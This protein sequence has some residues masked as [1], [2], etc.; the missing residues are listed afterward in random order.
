MK[1]FY[2]Q[3]ILLF[4]LCS[5]AFTINSSTN[6]NLQGWANSEIEFL[7]NDSSCPSS[8]DVQ[9]IMAEAVEIW[10][11]VSTSSLK[12]KIGGTTTST[13]YADKPTVYCETN[14]AGLSGSPDPN[15]VPGAAAVIGSTGSITHGLFF[16]NASAGLAN[17]AN[18]DRTTLKIIFA[19]EIGHILGLG[20]S[21]SLNALM[22]YDA[23]EKKNFRLSQD[24]ID[25]VS[26]LYPSNELSDSKIAGCGLVKNLPPPSGGE[27]T[28]IL[29]LLLLPFSLYNGLKIKNVPNFL[30]H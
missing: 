25:G 2:F 9:G 15:Y 10:N 18:F 21:E 28:L 11:N 16:L 23:S 14:F 1:Y 22:Y 3:S 24:D 17:I 20:H 12:V 26:Y 4:T 7:I 8:V 6:S 5:Q 30:V 19:H 13:T 29:F 27:L